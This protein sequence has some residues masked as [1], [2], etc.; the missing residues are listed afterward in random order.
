MTISNKLSKIVDRPVWEWCR[1]NPVGNTAAGS[2]LCTNDDGT[3]RM[4]YYLH[5]NTTTFYRYDTWTDAWQLLAPA[6]TAVGTV[7]SALKYSAYGGWRGHV[8]AATST[9]LTVPGLQNNVLLKTVDGNAVKV[10]IMTGTGAGQEKTVTAVAAPVVADYGVATSG[11]TSTVVDSIKKWKFNQWRGYQVRITFG[12]GLGQIRKIMYNDQTTLYVSENSHQGFEPWANA[13][14]TVAPAAASFYVIESNVVTINTAWTTVPD[15]TST[16]LFLTGTIWHLT[17]AATPGWGAFACYDIASDTWYPKTVPMG[18]LSAALV[19]DW[20]IER[21][22]EVSGAYQAAIAATN[23]GS[24]TIRTFT[25]TVQNWTVDQWVGYQIRISV[26]TCAGQRR[27]IIGNT[28]TTITV[29]RPFDT[30]PGTTDTYAIYG[31]TDKIYM[32]GSAG[33]TMLQY[34]VE[35]DLWA[36]SNAYDWGTGRIGSVQ[37]KT[38]SSLMGAQEAVPLV[39]IAYNATGMLTAPVTTAGSGYVKADIGTI[40]TVASTTGGTV[41][42]TGITDAGGVASVEIVNSGTNGTAGSRALT[43]G[44]GTSAAC[45]ITVGKIGL[46][47]T[48]QAHNFKTGDVVLV[49]GAETDANWNGSTTI[50]GVSSTTVFS[51][52]PSNGAASASATFTAQSATLVRDTSQAWLA[53]EHTGKMC[54]LY[55]APTAP[56]LYTIKAISASKITSNTTNALTLTST[57]TTAPDYQTRYVICDPAALGREEQYKITSQSNMGYAT[58]ATASSLVDSTKSWLLGQWTGYKVRIISGTGIA[59][60][61]Q[62]I[63]ASNSTSITVASWA[64]ATPDSTSKYIIMDTFGTVTTGGSTTVITDATKNWVSGALVGKR[65]RVMSG[66]NTGVEVAI[67]ANTATTWTTGTTLTSTTTDMTYSILSPPPK[68]SSITLQWMYNTSKQQKGRYLISARGNSPYWDIYDICRNTWDYQ[69][70]ITPQTEV[71]VAGSMY[72]YDG[73]DK[74]YFTI[75]ATGRVQ[76]L[77]LSNGTIAGSSITPYAHGTALVGNKMEIVTTADGLDYIYIMRHTG[78]EMWRAL[79][80]WNAW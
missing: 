9:G 2:V 3:G 44:T 28:A 1:F 73:G 60:G 17:T 18:N 14:F 50:L 38:A 77:D 68:A 16:F 20:A 7:S 45:T 43:G 80:F 41:I 48:A 76:I 46:F 8:L 52:A 25:D 22:G 72:A 35:N 4:M 66:V 54:V 6:L 12:T 56:G 26:G 58:S 70:F 64:A 39:S 47:T 74:L 36:A 10:R 29:Q 19:T 31:D 11:S 53:N 23:A 78:A 34:S 61:E 71:L 62:A 65:V 79:A 75:G 67:T 59:N 13:L 55:Q 49:A 30:T 37:L 32:V 5:G 21:T 63:T 15:T 27:R 57:V 69:T 42:I 24:N 33:S 40:C 51:A